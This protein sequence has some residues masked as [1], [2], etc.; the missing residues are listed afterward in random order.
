[1]NSNRISNL[2]GLLRWIWAL[3][4]PVGFVVG[5]RMA[6]WLSS[7]GNWRSVI[8]AST[9]ALV[10]WSSHFLLAPLVAQAADKEK[11]AVSLSGA[12]VL[13][14]TVL[15]FGVVAL[16]PTWMGL[17]LLMVAH[18]LFVRWLTDAVAR[19]AL[20]ALLA[21]LGIPVLLSLLILTFGRHLIVWYE[22]QDSTSPT[23]TDL[24][25]Y[26]WGP[27][28]LFD[29]DLDPYDNDAWRSLLASES[30]DV[31]HANSVIQ[32]VIERNLSGDRLGYVASPFDLVLFRTFNVLGFRTLYNL[33]PPLVLLSISAAIFWLSWRLSGGGLSGGFSSSERI[34]AALAAVLLMVLLFEPALSSTLG[35]GQVE[36]LYVPLVIVALGL[37]AKIPA[38][39]WVPLLAGAAL[40][41]AAAIKVFPAF[42]GLAL[43]W[44]AWRSLPRLRKK[45]GAFEREWRSKELRTLLWAA[46]VGSGLVLVTLASVGLDTMAS[47]VSKL[48]QDPFLQEVRWRHD[49]LSHFEFASERWIGRGIALST[50]VRCLLVGLLLVAGWRYFAAGRGPLGDGDDQQGTP[51]RVFHRDG[52]RGPG[53][54]RAFLGFA[55]LCLLALPSLMPLWWNLYH[56]VLV[57]PM[58]LC[59]WLLRSPRPDRRGRGLRR[60]G[61]LLL[62]LSY[63]GL[64]AYALLDH[65]LGRLSPG[66]L[67][68]L[69]LIA[70]R[71]L[72]ELVGYPGTLFLI[73]ALFVSFRY[74]SSPVNDRAVGRLTR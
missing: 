49:L 66:F 48:G 59:Y 2:A 55:S 60:A 70:Q 10:L 20:R 22:L 19:I 16:T 12:P 44:G 23:G 14:M 61:G 6:D 7:E 67:G 42:L 27:V 65:V 33:W 45:G 39:R 72:A 52:I 74:S 28:V 21:V 30:L 64:N 18:L 36:G 68:R 58:L 17:L 35:F 34:L 62:A 8:V 37:L 50:P 32:E 38:S 53:I 71:T 56:I 26:Y 51:D 9:G 1:M 46:V 54:D 5:V 47:W 40:A 29:H 41:L 13:L 57:V 11:A 15:F 4:I 73:A 69:P 24:A 25:T 3:W 43:L 31:G 63:C